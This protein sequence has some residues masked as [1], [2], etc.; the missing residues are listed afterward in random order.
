MTDEENERRKKLG[1]VLRHAALREQA[2]EVDALTA[3]ERYRR[4]VA[5]LVAYAEERARVEAAP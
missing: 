4:R 5:N 1:V 2:A 3:A